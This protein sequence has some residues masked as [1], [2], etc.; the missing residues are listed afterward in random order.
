MV[1]VSLQTSTRPLA[2][3]TSRAVGFTLTVHESVVV[4]MFGPE[5]FLHCGCVRFIN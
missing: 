4:N 1:S 5:T 2:L 3:L